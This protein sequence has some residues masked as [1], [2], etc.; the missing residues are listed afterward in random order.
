MS[1]VEERP[2]NCQYCGYDCA[3]I[4]TVEDGRVTGLR[5]DPARYPYVGRRSWPHAGAGP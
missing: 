2:S 3:V 4:A 1:A 5:P